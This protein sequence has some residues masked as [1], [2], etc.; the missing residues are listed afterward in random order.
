MKKYEVQAVEKTVI[1]KFI[2]AESKEEAEKIMDA[3]MNKPDFKSDGEFTETEVNVIH[4]EPYGIWF[5]LEQTYHSA[6]D[7]T[8]IWE[9]VYNGDECIRERICGYYHGEPD[10]ESF[11]E[12]AFRGVEGCLD[13]EFDK[14]TK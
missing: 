9:F 2:V 4:E 1:R 10:E 13:I 6:M 12:Y 8:I 7:C 5:K 11:K 14:L 3:I